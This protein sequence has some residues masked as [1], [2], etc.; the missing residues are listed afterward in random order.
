MNGECLRGKKRF[1]ADVSITTASPILEASYKDS[2]GLYFGKDVSYG[3]NIF[4]WYE[5]L[6]SNDK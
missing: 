2:W 4:I 1:N 5:K 6:T 3:L